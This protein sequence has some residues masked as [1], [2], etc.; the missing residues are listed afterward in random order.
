MQETKRLVSIP[1]LGKSP[2]VGNDNLL[3]YSCLENAMDRET[4]WATIHGVLKSQTLLNTHTHTHT[5]THIGVATIIAL[6]TWQQVAQSCPTLYDSV[7]CSPP[8]S[9]IH[10]VLQ[11]RIPEWVA[12]SFSRGSSRPRDRIQVSHI[13]GR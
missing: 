10:R 6:Y 13:E 3:Q 12:V 4:W 9:S 11:A 1:V 2:G 5:H 8:S 7:D